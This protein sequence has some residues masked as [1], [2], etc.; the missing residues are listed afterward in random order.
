ML[1]VPDVVDREPGMDL[2]RSIRPESDLQARGVS[3]WRDVL[4]TSTV[5]PRRRE[6][7][8]LEFRV[9]VG[10]GVYRTYG[11]LDVGTDPM[12]DGGSAG[13]EID[14]ARQLDNSRELACG[15]EH[16]RTEIDL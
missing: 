6:R 9:D 5:G 11:T 3:V 15:A 2:T 10:H 8:R 14:V 13:S 16:E 12:R 7:C 4:V 1:V